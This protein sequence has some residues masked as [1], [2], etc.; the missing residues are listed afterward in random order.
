MEMEHQTAAFHGRTMK[1]I[2]GREVL[3]AIASALALT[4]LMEIALII[5]GGLLTP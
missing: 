3:R 1:R 2:P 5:L 4:V